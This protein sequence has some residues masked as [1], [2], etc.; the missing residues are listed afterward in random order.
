[1]DFSLVAFQ[2]SLSAKKK[3]IIGI[4]FF[5]LTS[6]AQQVLAI[7]ASMGSRIIPLTVGGVRT[8]NTAVLNHVS[9][10]LI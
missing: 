1:M 2:D 6:T 3:Y 4:E 5:G 8:G 7:D 10:L 9:E